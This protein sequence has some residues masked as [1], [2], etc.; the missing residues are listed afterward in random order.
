LGAV[1]LSAV[2]DAVSVPGKRNYCREIALS[3]D[4]LVNSAV[5]KLTPDLVKKFEARQLNFVLYLQM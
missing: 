2:I 4:R 5:R 3:I 1:G